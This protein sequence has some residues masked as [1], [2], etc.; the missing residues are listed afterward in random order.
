ME[1]INDLVGYKNLKIY[2]NDELN[3]F[4]VDSMILASFATIKKSTKRIL[5]IGTGNA[6][7]P[8][9]LTI[10]TKAL[11]FGI[12]I[13]EELYK[14]AE[15]SVKI[16]MKGKQI[17]IIHDDLKNLGNHFELHTFDL[18][19]SN[20]P[21]FKAS[22]LSHINPNEAKAIARHEIMATLDDVIK[23]ASLMLNNNGVFSMVHRPDR[24]SDIITTMR[25]YRIEPKRIRFVYPNE[26]KESNQVLVEGIYCGK[27]DGLKIMKPLY[28]HPRQDINKDEIIKI[29]N[30]AIKEW[31]IC[32]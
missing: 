17:S 10:R 29:Y 12:E 2:Q 6:P 8:L 24:L 11:I 7:I 4:S 1:Q 20:P 23:Q 28:V 16:N 18:V 13:Q 15:K 31:G 26:E 14:L 25:K 30:G 27:P 3:S 19:L 32:S 22:E 9:Y 5:D 21:F